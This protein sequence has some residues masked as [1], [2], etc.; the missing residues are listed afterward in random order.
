MWKLISAIL[1]LAVVVTIA[2]V[3]WNVT[4][5]PPSEGEISHMLPW[6]IEHLD[7]G[8]TRAL[9]LSPG[10]D[11]LSAARPI[12]GPDAEIAIVAPP[13]RPMLLEAYYESVNAG[14]ITGRLILT[15]D[16]NDDTLAAMRARALRESYMESTTRKIR[17]HPDD[18]ATARTAPIRVITF[19]PSANLDE[20][21]VSARFGAAGERIEG[22]G[23]VVH[24]L[25]PNKG[26][27]IALDG[28]GRAVMQ[29][30]APRD[31]ARLASPLATPSTSTTIDPSG[32]R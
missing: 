8:H 4:Q 17:L 32:A 10:V 5:A 1:T 18:L 11:P 16:L 19:I 27:D 7:D 3:L 20:E 9:G 23:G 13:G 26:L 2:P 14:F 28:R 12:F 29:Y 25:Y 6:Q 24:L 31:F 21:V 15:A 30:V 22:E